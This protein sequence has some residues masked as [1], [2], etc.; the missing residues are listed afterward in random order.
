MYKYQTKTEQCIYLSITFLLIFWKKLLMA[1]CIWRTKIEVFNYRRKLFEESRGGKVTKNAFTV[2]LCPSISTCILPSLSFHQPFL[3]PCLCPCLS[4]CLSLHVS[5]F[6]SSPALLSVCFH[7]FP[8]SL[9]IS[10]FTS[11]YLPLSLSLSVSLSLCL[12]VS[13]SLSLSLSLSSFHSHL[14][15]RLTS[16]REDTKCKNI[17]GVISGSSSSKSE[18]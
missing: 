2:D 5:H 4:P 15:C 18:K 3:L 9:S 6:A 14:V 1:L 10:Y 13:L 11:L 17:S 16:Q 7:L 8:L 12:S